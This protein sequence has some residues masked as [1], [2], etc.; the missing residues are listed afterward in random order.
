[1]A[2]KICGI[3]H[4]TGEYQ[5]RAY[6]NYVIYSYEDEPKTNDNSTLGVC[7]EGQKVKASVLH[8]YISADRVKELLGKHV[9][10]Y[11][12]SYQQVSLIKFE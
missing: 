8:Q 12:D 1:M 3:A 11:F 4:R 10:F 2:K 7:P 9:E 5:G 6:D